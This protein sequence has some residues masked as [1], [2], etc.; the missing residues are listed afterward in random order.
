MVQA[1]L[2]PVVGRWFLGVGDEFTV[3]LPRVG[4]HRLGHGLERH[5][6]VQVGAHEGD[7]P[8][9]TVVLVDAFAGSLV[10]LFIGPLIHQQVF[11]AFLRPHRTAMPA[12]Q[13]GRQVDRRAAR[14]GDDTAV[15]HIALVDNGSGQREALLELIAQ[16]EM[17]RATPAIEQA[18]LAQ[19]ERARAQGDDRDIGRMHLTQ[20][21]EQPT[22]RIARFAQQ[23][24]R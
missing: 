18:C 16:S 4:T 11:Q 20:R 5:R 14:A 23:P 17:Q 7:G 9:H 6:C 19:H 24:A 2:A 21:V 15:I 22:W 12:D 3:Q 13:V 10:V 1:Q 8:L